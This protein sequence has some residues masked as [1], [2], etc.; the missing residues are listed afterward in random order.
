VQLFVQLADFLLKLLN[1]P[2]VLLEVDLQPTQ[3]GL[4]VPQRHLQLVVAHGVRQAQGKVDRT[5]L[6]VGLGVTPTF[7]HDAT[8]VSTARHS[9]R[10]ALRCHIPQ[11]TRLIAS[12][13]RI[14]SA[15][16]VTASAGTA[17][18]STSAESGG[19]SGQQQ[20]HTSGTRGIVSHFVRA[21]DKSEL[22]ERAFAEHQRLQPSLDG[23]RGRHQSERCRWQVAD[24]GRR[25]DIADGVLHR[26]SAYGW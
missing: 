3:L 11:R 23:A 2:A 16:R 24:A 4:P 26:S 10:P 13:L 7:P 25:Y 9:Q 18:V 12:C 15:S 8:V 5:Q 1:R 22:Q 19:S 14:M 17:T 21:R 6:G 20:S